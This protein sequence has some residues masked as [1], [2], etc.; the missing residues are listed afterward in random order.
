MERTDQFFRGVELR[1]D[2]D[3]ETLLVYVFKALSEA[4]EMF[5]FLRDFRSTAIIASPAAKVTQ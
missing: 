4:T 2:Q 5:V 1:V 3:G